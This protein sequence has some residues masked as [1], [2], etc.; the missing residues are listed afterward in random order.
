MENLLYCSVS[1]NW[2]CQL[3]AIYIIKLFNFKTSWCVKVSYPMA[4][5]IIN[6]AYCTWCTLRTG[7]E[8]MAA[9][10]QTTWKLLVEISFH[11]TSISYKIRGVILVIS[12]P[13]MAGVGQQ[14]PSQAEYQ[15]PL[16]SRSAETYKSWPVSMPHLAPDNFPSS[17]KTKLRN[18]VPMESFLAELCLP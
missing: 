8:E 16:F 14:T 13:A 6:T 9:L 2:S 5:I 10:S 3:E 1:G 18:S 15:V 17:A 12:I 4:S 7:Q 11:S